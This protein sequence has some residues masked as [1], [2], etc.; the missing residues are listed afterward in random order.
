M[1]SST[2][3]LYIVDPEFRAEKLFYIDDIEDFLVQYDEEKLVLSN[4]QYQ[5]IELNKVLK[6][7]L[8]QSYQSPVKQLSYTYCKI[9]NSDNAKPVYFWVKKL[10]WR[11]ESALELEL[12]MDC[13]NTFRITSDYRFSP[14][15]L[16]QRQ[17]KDR[18]E[19]SNKKIYSREKVSMT[20][21]SD[22][23]NSK[24]YMCSMTVQML[25]AFHTN[26]SSW[27]T[28]ST[29]YPDIV[30]YDEFLNPRR[31][32]FGVKEI[33]CGPV[34]TY[35]PMIRIKTTGVDYVYSMAYI[36]FLSKPSMSLGTPMNL[37]VT[38]GYS[39]WEEV[40]LTSDGYASLI[41]KIDLTSEE[42]NP[43]LYTSSFKEIEDLNSVKED[44]FLVYDTNNDDD[45][46][47][48]CYLVP[49][50]NTTVDISQVSMS[51]RVISAGLLTE[52]INYYINNGYLGGTIYD[53]A[54][55][56][57]DNGDSL[58]STSGL[59][60]LQRKGDKIIVNVITITS[61]PEYYVISRTY[62]TDYLT[63]TQTGAI[64]YG[65]N[66]IDLSIRGTASGIS[67]DTTWTSGNTWNDDST[68][69][70]SGFVNMD[71]SKSTLLKVIRCP[72]I[73]YFFETD[74]DLLVID[75][76]W[77]I[78]SWNG[79]GNV[80][81][82]KSLNT[83]FD[84]PLTIENVNELNEEILYPLYAPEV[85]YFDYHARNDMLE[86][87]MFHSE[88]SYWKFFYDSFSWSFKNELSNFAVL[89][90]QSGDNPQVDITLY[91]TSTINSRFAFKFLNIIYT[92]PLIIK[93]QDY[94]NWL[95]I[96]R[97]NEEV[98]YNSSYL[99]YIRSGFNY[100]VKNKEL[101]TAVS[102]GGAVASIGMTGLAIAGAVAS[103]GA[104]LPLAI[105]AIS[106][107][108][109]SAMT[110]TNAITT[111]VQNERSI[112]QKLDQLKM[113]T[114]SVNQADTIDLMKR[115]GKNRLLV[116][117]Y[118]PSP[119][120]KELLLDLFYYYGYK[121]NVC[122]IPD[123]TSRLNFNYLKCEPILLF[124]Q[125]NVTLECRNELEN[126]YRTGVTIIH[127]FKNSWDIAQQSGNLETWLYTTGEIPYYD[128]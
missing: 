53:P 128:L 50:E 48:D 22:W 90:E 4:Y 15:T 79:L 99:N 69:A 7:E 13:L 40:K 33:S 108:V 92:N 78:V 5:R 30:V 115:Y 80:L 102:W 60:E 44:W 96:Q 88:F 113:Q 97:N 100:D 41:R 37:F 104:T 11:S 86:S 6:L 14:K 46:V 68:R 12:V 76:K 2:I 35:G 85:Y 107:A 72:Y 9:V 91:T 8:S 55:F 20:S 71:K 77:E 93:E 124:S 120:M 116:T 61:A 54:N 123:I 1:A 125:E 56:K 110:L 119:R 18:F 82:L 67:F 109:T 87:K 98:I 106:G 25:L 63:Y 24:I 42:I 28:F 118:E 43:V 101:S 27:L 36:A 111:T 58:P 122:E 117:H 31:I 51:G 114:A 62:I 59:M 47:I 57:L 45:T 39:N 66:A 49:E 52:G 121:D 105:M 64:A 127:K 75:N 112:Q 94:Y 83:M 74:N 126:C 103:Q 23:D 19:W 81:H 16:I 29:P 95:L 32:F 84:N 21:P 10:N 17:H 34:G 70:L 3:T 65:S 89:I 26:H 73:P 38:N